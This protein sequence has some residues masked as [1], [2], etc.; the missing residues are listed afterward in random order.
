MTLTVIK[1]KQRREETLTNHNT[2]G[3][4][5]GENE[6]HITLENCA[7]CAGVS[8]CV[9]P[10]AVQKYVKVSERLQLMKTLCF[11]R[12]IQRCVQMGLKGRF[13]KSKMRTF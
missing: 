10:Y 8:E 2:R 5:P 9:L 7:Q 1:H 11:G 3:R 13:F 6:T 12:P 4:K